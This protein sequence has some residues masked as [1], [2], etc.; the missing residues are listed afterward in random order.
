MHISMHKWSSLFCFFF[1][2]LM[3]VSLYQAIAS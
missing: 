1:P 3:P 2:P